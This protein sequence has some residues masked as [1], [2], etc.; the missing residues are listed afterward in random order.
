MTTIQIPQR[1]HRLAEQLGL[2]PE[3]VAEQALEIGT[4]QIDFN[5]AMGLHH[6]QQDENPVDVTAAMDQLTPEEIARLD[7]GDM[8]AQSVVRLDLHRKAGIPCGF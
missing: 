3:L 1:I 2:D 6:F 5:L 4:R 8:S 7:R